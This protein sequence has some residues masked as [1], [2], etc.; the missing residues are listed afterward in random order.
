MAAHLR[1]F[2]ESMEAESFAPQSLSVRV[3]LGD[4]LPLIASAQRRNA[5]WL[6][7]F[8][9]DE[10]SVTSDLYEVLRAFAYYRPSA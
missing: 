1:V 9:D 7:D 10:V 5:L 3:R 8:L 4:L 2:P 6:R